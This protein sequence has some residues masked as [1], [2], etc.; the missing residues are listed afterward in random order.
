[1]SPHATTPTQ[2][3]PSRHRHFAFVLSRE[4]GRSLRLHLGD[5]VV[6][7]GLELGAVGLE[8]QV[9]VDEPRSEANA[10]ELEERRDERQLLHG[11]KHAVSHNERGHGRAGDE[12]RGRLGVVLGPGSLRLLEVLFGLSGKV[13]GRCARTRRETG[14]RDRDER[15]REEKERKKGKVGDYV[16]GRILNEAARTAQTL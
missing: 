3:D 2:P 15:A 7:D 4:N 13:L 12:Q 10:D 6:D 16:S 1:M 5:E 11:R 9:A 8:E 14:K